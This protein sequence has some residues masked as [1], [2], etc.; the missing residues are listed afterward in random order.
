MKLVQYIII[1][2]ILV[3]ISLFVGIFVSDQRDNRKT[4]VMDANNYLDEKYTSREAKT[5]RE[6]TIHNFLDKKLGRD[7]SMELR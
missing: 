6:K 7:Y 4:E 3:T 1:C 2:L 5:Q